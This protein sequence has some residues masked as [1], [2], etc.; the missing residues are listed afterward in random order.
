MP[1]LQLKS[2][3]SIQI[4]CYI[5]TYIFLLLLMVLAVLLPSSF[6]V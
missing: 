2:C 4:Y 3:A 6:R 5:G 1:V